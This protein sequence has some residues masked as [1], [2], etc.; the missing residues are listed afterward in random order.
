MARGMRKWHIFQ[1]AATATHDAVMRDFTERQ[2]DFEIWQCCHARCQIIAAR[3]DF[4]RCRFVLRRHTAH[5]I[6][7][8]AIGQRHAVIYVMRIRAVGKAKF[9]E[10]LVK[11]ITRRIARERSPRSISPFKAGRKT[12]NQQLGVFIAKA[13]HGGVEPIWMRGACVVAI[14]LKARA[15]LAIGGRVCCHAGIL[16]VFLLSTS[17]SWR[18]PSA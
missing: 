15:K 5:G 3:V 12:D 14:G 17:G 4:V 2:N 18:K 8:H 10:R 6:G 11:Q 7:N 1:L 16:Q 9:S 13:R